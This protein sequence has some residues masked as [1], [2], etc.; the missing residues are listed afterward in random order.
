MPLI[1]VKA[2]IQRLRKTASV[3]L[4]N[5]VADKLLK[6]VKELVPVQT[7]TLQR[8]YYLTYAQKPGDKATLNNDVPYHDYVEYGTPIMSP[9]GMVAAAIAAVST[10]NTKKYIKRGP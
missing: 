1:G 5:K 7:G 10:K 8:G 6:K 3:D 9:R 2:T 4:C